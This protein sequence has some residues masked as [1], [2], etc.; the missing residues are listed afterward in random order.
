MPTSAQARARSAA[1]RALQ[2]ARWRI[3]DAHRKSR[4]LATRRA[5][6]RG[7]RVNAGV[8]AVDIESPIGL[9]GQLNWCLYIF[10]HC[11]QNGLRPY[12]RL[13]GANYQGPGPNRN[14]FG[15]HFENLEL[16]DRDRHRIDAGEIVTT[17]VRLLDEVPLDREFDAELTLER[18]NQLVKRYLGIKPAVLDKVTEFRDRHAIGRN[19]LGVHYR[20]TDK[21]AEAPRVPWEACRD[22]VHAYLASHP[23][24]DGLF[25]SSDEQSFVDYLVGEVRA[26]TVHAHDDDF[27]SLNGQ[28]IHAHATDPNGDRK[29]AEAIVNCLLLA[30]CSGVVRTSSFLSAWSSVFNPDLEV[31]LLNRPFD[32]T[33]WFPERAIV[34]T[35]EARTAGSQP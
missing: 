6:A 27:R 2:G 11:D 9:F 1:E 19:T 33:F 28:A 3:L 5:F 8:F 17:K 22:A 30:Q 13:S 35:I 31:I 29:G 21:V 12:I 4:R 15:Y 14:W 34:A 26:V 20:G 7:A 16:T 24:I 23:E 32:G 10:A 18:A 25:V